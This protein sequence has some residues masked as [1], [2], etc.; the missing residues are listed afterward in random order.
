MGHSSESKY[1]PTTF[2]VI[3]LGNLALIDTT[4]GNEIAENASGLLGSFGTAAN[5]LSKSIQTLSADRL[6][7]DDNSTYDTD[8][9]GGYDSFRINGG[10]PQN[11]DAISAYD[12]TITY[13]DGTNATI[14]AVVFQDVN[15]NTYLAPELSLNADQAALTAKPIQSLRT[16]A[17]ITE[18]DGAV[19]ACGGM[20][21]VQGIPCSCGE[22]YRMGHDRPARNRAKVACGRLEAGRTGSESVCCKR[23]ACGGSRRCFCSLGDH[24]ACT[25]NDRTRTKRSR[26]AV[27]TERQGAPRRWW[28][29]AVDGTR[30]DAACGPEALG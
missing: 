28:S 13:F 14:S 12:A 6:S 20:S 2:E 30:S 27:A 1:M 7:E 10:A 11:F 18:S 24:G 17:A 8:N 23:G 15:G 4:Q 19:G 16:Q 9:G 3:F 25:L 21:P 22:D 5:P 26:Q 29:S